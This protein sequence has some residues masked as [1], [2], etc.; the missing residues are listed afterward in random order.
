M[1]AMRKYSIK[2][3]ISRYL[4]SQQDLQ[5]HY[6]LRRFNTVIR[7]P[8]LWHCNRHSIAIACFIGL[9]VAMIP[10]PMQMLIAASS[11]ALFQAN[12]PLSVSLVWISNPITMPPIFYF[13]YQLGANLLQV[14]TVSLSNA[15][16][17]PDAF[18]LDNITSNFL[19]VWLPLLTGSL[20]IGTVLGL[21]GFY[22]VNWIWRRNVLL[23]WHLRKKTAR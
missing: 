4:P 18:A 8:R 10:L 1:T 16:L 6:Y 14:E 23:R 2:K 3:Q 13:A 9:F 17:S 20:L 12:L 5:K 22:T 21:A 7:Q 11:A 15:T 19:S